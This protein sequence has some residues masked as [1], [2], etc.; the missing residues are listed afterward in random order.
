MPVGLSIDWMPLFLSLF[1][2]LRQ[3]KLGSQIPM[4]YF[5][6]QVVYQITR[7]SSLGI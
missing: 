3:E 7:P 5:L 6:D 2:S 4:L 1:V